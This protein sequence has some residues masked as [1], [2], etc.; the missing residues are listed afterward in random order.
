MCF[1][2]SFS[3]FISCRQFLIPFRSFQMTLDEK[4]G[5]KPTVQC[6]VLRSLVCLVTYVPFEDKYTIIILSKDES[7]NIH[8]NQ[9]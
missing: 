9:H 2:G 4:T 8:V 7:P 5:L 6:R 3:Y 1:L